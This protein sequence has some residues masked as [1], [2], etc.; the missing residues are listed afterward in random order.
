[1]KSILFVLA[2]LLL[3]STA[4]AETTCDY[5]YFNSLERDYFVHEKVETGELCQ[6]LS[7]HLLSTPQR[8]DVTEKY[9]RAILDHLGVKITGRSY[10]WDR[11]NIQINVYYP[12]DQ[13]KVIVRYG[14]VAFMRHTDEVRVLLK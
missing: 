14:T 10:T 2:G 4:F 3:S 6:S 7:E 9:G 11:E 5:E 1:M 8:R 13:N 12:T